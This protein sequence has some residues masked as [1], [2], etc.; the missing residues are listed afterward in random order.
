MTVKGALVTVGDGK[1]YSNGLDLEWMAGPGREHG[2]ACVLP[3]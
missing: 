3:R 1:F 2:P